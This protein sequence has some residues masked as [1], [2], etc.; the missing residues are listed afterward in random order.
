MLIVEQQVGRANQQRKSNMI[1]Y[2]KQTKLS[3]KEVLEKA[4]AYFGPKGEGLEI[5]EQDECH[6]S[7]QGGGG[8]VT[9]Q[10]CPAEKV[11][12][13]DLTTKEWEFQAKEFIGKL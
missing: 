12:D 11:T 8:Y 6:I 2:G 3:A 9:V 1:R 5:R 7:F 10:A 4:S 13:V